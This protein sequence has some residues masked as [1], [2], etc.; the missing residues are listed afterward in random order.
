M[1]TIILTLDNGNKKEYVK[2][3]KLKEIIKKLKDACSFEEKLWQ[4]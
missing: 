4:T 1:E 2:G 3:I